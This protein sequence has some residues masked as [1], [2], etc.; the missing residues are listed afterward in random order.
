MPLKSINLNEGLQKISNMAFY[1]NSEAKNTINEITIPDSVTTIGNSILGNRVVNTL[2]IGD[3]VAS[4]DSTMFNKLI[5]SNLNIGKNSSKSQ[6]ILEDGFKKA[7]IKS[8]KMIPIKNVSLLKS[9]VKQSRTKPTINNVEK[10]WGLE[11]GKRYCLICVDYQVIN[12]FKPKM[13]A[14]FTRQTLRK[15]ANSG[16]ASGLAIEIKKKLK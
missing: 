9:M 10:I 15:I 14:L 11:I 12:G 16:S 5:V 2:N 4:M 3:G 6:E 13:L 7:G 1:L 8:P